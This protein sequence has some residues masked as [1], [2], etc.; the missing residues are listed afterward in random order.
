M[1]A[2]T[3]GATRS[4]DKA[5]EVAEREGTPVKK[6]GKSDEPEMPE[7][8]NGYPGGW[9]WNNLDLAKVAAY[10]AS[11]QAGYDFSVYEIEADGDTWEV[12][13]YKGDDGEHH[14]LKDALV[15]GKA[16]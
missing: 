6:I 16:A 13:A 14:L 15:V 5:L 8:P 2:W 11:V 12:V 3:I 1:K 9:V 10:E 4:Y 7:Y